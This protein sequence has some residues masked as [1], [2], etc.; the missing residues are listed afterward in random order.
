MLLR[1]IAAVMFAA[2]GAVIGFSKAEGLRNDLELCRETGEL[3]RMSAILIR[4]QG[5]DVY[6][7]SARLKNSSDLH[8]LT[9]LN[10]LPEGFSEEENFH[11]LWK[12]AVSGQENIPE[13]ERM[14]LL[15]FGEI[16][17]TSDIP[18]QMT[19]IEAIGAELSGIESR[20]RENFIRKS[21]LYRSTC[22]LFGIM[23]GILII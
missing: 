18:G 6:Q 22:T 19:S 14:I 4:F 16:I 15:N 20:R 5:L 7:L 10:S 3:L 13:E 21:R 11:D 1:L 9:F 2:A 23:A 17:G 12:K 8:K